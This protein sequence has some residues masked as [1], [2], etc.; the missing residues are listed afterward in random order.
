MIFQSPLMLLLLAVIPLL[1]KVLVRGHRLREAAAEQLRGRRAS[2]VVWKQTMGRQLAAFVLLVLALARP[3]WNPHPGPAAMHGR[4]LVIALDISRSMLAAD[5]F[6]SR[7][8]AAKIALHETL[9]HLRGQRV[10]LILFAGAASVRVPLTRDH[11]FVRYMLDRAAPSEA[12]VG[13]TSL[14]SAI[15]KAV[16]VVLRESKKGQQ[17]LI[18]FTDGEDHISNIDE[19]R[20]ALHACGARVLIIGL[21]DPVTGAPVPAVGGTN[22]WMQ[23]KESRVVSRLDE[24]KLILLS[25]ETP[26]V[27]YHPARTG[28][29]DLLAL[30]QQVLASPDGIPDPE[31]GQVLYTE[32]YPFLV[33]LALAFLFCLPI[34]K[35]LPM[36]VVLLVAGCGLRGPASDA[37]YERRFES[38]RSLWNEAQPMIDAEP[39]A[40]LPMLQEAREA[41]LCAALLHPGDVDAAQQVAGITRQ[42]HAVER[43]IERQAPD[44]PPQNG[45]REGTQDASRMSDD[46]MDWDFD[47]DMEWSESDAASA[48]SMPMSAGEFKAALESRMLPSPN[49]TAEEV[50]LQEAA[51]QE[52]R[53]QQ[54]E[55]RSGAKVEKNW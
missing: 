5:V 10:G 13:S 17:D 19:T 16:D 3:G 14:Q 55:S 46:G 37:E 8:E 52:K 47:E 50:M 54:R 42:I 7:L 49:Y 2:S 39:S 27:T 15:E 26:G 18:I 11:E 32:G 6:P 21:G 33:A 40:A 51:N 45:D 30:Y 31:G 25:S 22:A 41:F 34:R 9:P 36:M 29:F 53:A 20:E 43:A 48:Q 12:Q 35:L 38:G 28:A 24:E 23:Y 4:D 44:E 1:G